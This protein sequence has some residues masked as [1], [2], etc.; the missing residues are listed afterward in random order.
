MSSHPLEEILH[1]KSIAVVGA[2]A[3][4]RGGQFVEPLVEFGYKGKI[5]PVNPKYSE[6]LGMKAYPTLRDIPDTVD[7]VISVVP[8]REV[9]KMI[10]DASVKGVK[11]IHLFTARFTETGRPQAAA[12]EQEIL[13]LVKRYGIRLIGPNCMGVYYP[14]EGI[15]FM[16]EFPKKSGPV[17]FVSQ[18]GNVVGDTVNKATRRGVFFSKAISYGNAIDLNECD[19]L[20]YFAQDPETKIIIMYIEGAK[21]GKRFFDILRRTTPIKPVVII[22]GGKGQAGARATSSHTASLAGSYQ[23][24]EAMVAQA[25]AISVDT[26]D[27]L[28]DL[29]VSFRFLPPIRGKR[30]G[31]GGGAGGASVLAADECE[32]AGLDVV[33]LPPEFREEMKNKGISIWDWIS[34]PADLSIRENDDFTPGMVMEM[35]AKYPD[36]DLLI[37]IMGHMHRRFM[38]ADLTIDKYLAEQFC[39]NNCR[40]KPLLAVVPDMSLG[41]N[42]ADSWEWKMNCELRTRLVAEDVPFYT[43]V[44]QAASAARK[45][46]DYYNKKGWP[47]QPL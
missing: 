38:G 23:V 4:G 25:G 11:G 10:E 9:T 44:E 22:K 43:S 20:E 45:M 35:M 16:D 3:G 14:A 41:I 7:Y 37:A 40:I 1:P 42:E 13:K 30:V 33:P 15:T 18:S 47:S 31:V 24:W 29:A 34:N 36:F 27:E 2:S 46:I 17:A 26:L 5:Y 8:A 28:I 19:Y 6:V 32:R 21:D 12:L 39:L